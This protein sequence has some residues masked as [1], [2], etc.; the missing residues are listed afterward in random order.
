M[1][2]CMWVCMYVPR[3][4][5]RI[6]IR[7]HACMYVCMY[8]SYLCS[9]F[10]YVCMR[11]CATHTENCFCGICRGCPRM[12]TVCVVYVVLCG[13]N[14]LDKHMQKYEMLEELKGVVIFVS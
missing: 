14:I 13:L 1:Y 12:H 7:M 4:Y 5:M 6:Y 8:L 3:V 11:V 2:V 9:I 10:K